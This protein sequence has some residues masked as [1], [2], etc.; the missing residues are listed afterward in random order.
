[1]ILTEPRGR[2]QG[3]LNWRKYSDVP[4]LIGYAGGSPARATEAMSDAEAAAIMM[5]NLRTIFGRN[6]PDPT[7][8]A[9]SRWAM[10]HFSYG[11]Y[12]FLPVGAS[13]ADRNALAEPAGNRLFFAGEAT[14]VQYVGTLHGAYFSGER[15]ARRIAGS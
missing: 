13:A 8:I 9:R 12:S 15:E 1:M 5:E 6:V 11:A 2:W 14:H 4:A 3:M 10:D 7:G